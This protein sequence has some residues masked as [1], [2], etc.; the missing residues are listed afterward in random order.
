MTKLDH[1]CMETL[2]L[3]DFMKFVAKRNAKGE[4]VS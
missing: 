2:N 1:T 4:P 3:M